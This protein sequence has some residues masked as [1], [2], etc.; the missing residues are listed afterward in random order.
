MT[1]I[2]TASGVPA[3]NAKRAKDRLRRQLLNATV[4]KDGITYISV[5]APDEDFETPDD[6]LERLK[7]VLDYDPENWQFKHTK[8]E[9]RAF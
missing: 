3:E 4:T 5:V 7:V 2:A 6:L 9:A 1:I 8:F